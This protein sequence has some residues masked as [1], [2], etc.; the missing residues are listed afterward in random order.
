MK[1]RRLELGPSTWTNF[2]SANASIHCTFRTEVPKSSTV[3]SCRQSRAR[4]G[5]RR[6]EPSVK[7]GGFNMQKHKEQYDEL[8]FYTVYMAVILE[9]HIFT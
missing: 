3:S 2:I 7:G 5:Y 4:D 9:K 8:S 1:G 6:R